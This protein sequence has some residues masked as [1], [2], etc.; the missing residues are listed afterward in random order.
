MKR[1]GDDNPVDLERGV[2]ADAFGWYTQVSR[3]II[4][5]NDT[6]YIEPVV[7]V[8]WIDLDT[9]V[10]S[11][12]DRLTTAVGLIYSP[13]PNY[14]LKFEYDFVQERSGIPFGNNKLWAALVVEF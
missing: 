7:Q 10:P 9:D 6:S 8:D 12:K 4:L 11:N 1:S 3:R 13:E 2:S 5:P 14:L